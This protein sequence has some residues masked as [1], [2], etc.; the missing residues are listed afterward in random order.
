MM[1]TVSEDEDEDIFVCAAGKGS[2]YSVHFTKYLFWI[3]FS[4]EWAVGSIISRFNFTFYI[5][6]RLILEFFTF[7]ENA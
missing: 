6:L 2:I 3:L 1:F 7:W 4:K 5:F